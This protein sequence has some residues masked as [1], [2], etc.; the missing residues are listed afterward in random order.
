M[1]KEEITQNNAIIAKFMGLKPVE[2]KGRYSINKDHCMCREDTA[3]KALEG[4]SSIAKYNTSWEWLMPVVE[5]IEE[6]KIDRYTPFITI[7]N[8]ACKI[9]VG[10][11]DYNKLITFVVAKGNKHHNVY[12]AVVQFINWYNKN[13]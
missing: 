11:R 9:E 6:L 2:Y 5:K 10:K 7:T 8:Y 4:F 3:E 12:K 1:K 13:K